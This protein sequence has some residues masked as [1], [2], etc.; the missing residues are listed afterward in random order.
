LLVEDNADDVA[1]LKLALKN[2]VIDYVLDVVT[3]G[4]AAIQYLSDALLFAF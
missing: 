1:L 4:E 3:D 2:A